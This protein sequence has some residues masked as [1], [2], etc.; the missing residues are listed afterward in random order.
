MG[1]GGNIAIATALPHI[2]FCIVLFKHSHGLRSNILPS[3]GSSV[4][5]VENNTVPRCPVPDVCL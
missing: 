5:D 2:Q 4:S 3:T 1:D